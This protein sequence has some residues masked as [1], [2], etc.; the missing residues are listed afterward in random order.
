MSKIMIDSVLPQEDQRERGRR[1]KVLMSAYACEP[2]RGSEPGLGWNTVKHISQYHDVWM[3]TSTEHQAFVEKELAVNPMPNV[4]WHFVHVPKPWQG[5][6]LRRVHY[7][8]W[9]IAAYIQG[10][11][12]SKQ[13]PFDVVHHVSYAS[14][15]TPSF[16]AQLPIP[17]VWGPV[18]GGEHTPDAFI[19]TL[20]AVGRR[21]ERLRTLMIN[22]SQFDPWVR[23][24]VRNAVVALASTDETA[25]S[26]QKLG[27][28]DVRIMSDVAL[29]STELEEF[30]ALPSRAAATPLRII[31]VGRLIDS[32]AYQL[33]L[34]AF[35]EVVKDFPQSEYCIY[36]DG[37]LR[38][39][40]E[41]LAQQLGI[42][43]KVKFMG[44]VARSEVLRGLSQSDIMVHPSLHEAGGWAPAEAM[45]AGCPVVAL[46]L[47]G[48][49]IVVT[50][51]T[52]ILVEAITPDQAVHDMAD[53]IK[54]LAI[55]VDLRRAMGRVGRE[56]VWQNH[57]WDTHAEDIA[58]VYTEAVSRVKA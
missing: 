48:T 6:R 43:Q 37:Y 58:R 17:F 44:E 45:A 1:M 36:G 8:L 9:Q 22:I 52:G 16:L 4:Q 14:Y 10:K 32:K 54:H 34:R 56:H 23:R 50:P 46:A 11:K 33:G 42:T 41:A 13:V 29:S 35:A 25:L 26:I 47:A 49:K 20:S 55:D 38:A 15:W 21:H 27:G 3:L 57:N 39:D 2:H 19:P 7:Y 12:L 24:T 18:G 28:K 40:L 51:E 30:S 31:S 5:E 53:A